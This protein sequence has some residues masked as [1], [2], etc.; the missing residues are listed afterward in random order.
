M[1]R[2]APRT[3]KETAAYMRK[4]HGEQA[5]I[6]ATFHLMNHDRGTPAYAHWLLVLEYIRNPKYK[7][8]ITA[9]PAP[10][11]TPTSTSTE[12]KTTQKATPTPKPAAKTKTRSAR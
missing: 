4:T 7:A 5:S 12:R 3:P 1:R 2:V 10:T 6:H 8:P 11:P 9:K